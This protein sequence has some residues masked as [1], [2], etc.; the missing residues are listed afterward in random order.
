MS[1]FNS[2]KE[3]GKYG[4]IPHLSRNLL[5]PSPFSRV[6][7][8]GRPRLNLETGSWV[9]VGTTVE[10]APTPINP[11]VPVI[12]A[13]IL[14]GSAGLYRIVNVDGGIDEEQ[15]L[16][17]PVSVSQWA[18]PG[19]EV[20]VYRLAFTKEGPV[21]SFPSLG[22]TEIET[23]SAYAAGNT[24]TQLDANYDRTST[25]VPT[26][27]SA[28]AAGPAGLGV[29]WGL[30]SGSSPRV[31]RKDTIRTE[32]LTRVPSEVVQVLVKLRTNSPNFRGGIGWTN[33]S[34]FTGLATT[35]FSGSQTQLAIMT[36][37]DLGTLSNKVDLLAGIS[38][39]SIVWAR[40]EVEGNTIRGRAWYDGAGEPGSWN[41]R[42]HSNDLV[43]D[44]L[45]LVGRT[46]SS[47]HFCLGYSIG[48]TTAA[49]TF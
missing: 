42:S 23:W 34:V 11:V 25:N 26:P 19:E 3:V 43:F 47:S 36:E 6:A 29:Q 14:Y 21:V 40:F 44:H 46:G 38:N 12:V 39:G 1:S 15:N 10:R 7:S 22:F 4:P 33:S 28:D 32:L 35:Q 17:P 5:F 45:G 8:L 41:T 48:I 37:G 30:S 9:I 18:Q 20:T 49:P 16:T 2:S 24:F 31:A 13:G 27:V